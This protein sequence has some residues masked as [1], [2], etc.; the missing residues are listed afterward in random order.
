MLGLIVAALAWWGYG[1]WTES[2]ALLSGPARV[3]APSPSSGEAAGPAESLSMSDLLGE[4]GARGVPA[5]A[6]LAEAAPPP[7][8]DVVELIQRLKQRDPAAVGLAWLAIAADRL[9][10]QREQVLELLRPAGD[11]FDD[12]LAALGPHNGFLRSVEGRAAARAATT[13][14]MALP[15]AQAIDA[16][17]ALLYRMACGRIARTDL[18]WRKVVEEARVQHRIRVDRWLC[19]PTNVAGARVYTVKPGDSLAR[20]AKRFRREGVKVEAGT[21]AVLNRVS[22]PNSLHVGQSLKI[23]VAPIKAVLE[24]DSFALMIFVGDQLLRLYWVGHGANDHT[25]VTEFEVTA[26]QPRPDWTAPDG[27]VY[28]YG[29]PKNVLGEYFIKFGHPQYS[30]FGAHGTPEED[31]ICTESSMGCIRMFAPD[32]AELFTLLPR[33]AKVIVRDTPAR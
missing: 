26:K 25:P 1:K 20:I 21:I 6:P 30:G 18:E 22:N 24:K 31:T 33:G 27:N 7:P 23:P 10:A 28:A 8:S 12:H 16:G 32:I 9:G 4:G 17:T 3:A 19:N 2:E 5:A 15:D 14:A 13:A 11:G 29:H